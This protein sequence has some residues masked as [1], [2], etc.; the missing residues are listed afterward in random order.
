MRKF[1]IIAG[2]LVVAYLLFTNPTGAADGVRNILG[3]LRY[4]AEQLISF[5]GNLFHR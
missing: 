3:A 1:F 2:V 5:V 4:G